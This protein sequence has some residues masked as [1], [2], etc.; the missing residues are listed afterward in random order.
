M[1]QTFLKMQGLGNDFVI[2]DVRKGGAV[3]DIDRIKLVT[4]RRRGIG[5]DQVI[6]ILP[7]R[8][9]K[10]DV[11][12]DMYNPDGSSLQAC[13][14]ATRCVADYLM[15]EK[16]T[17]S[18]V[19][20]TVAGLLH[21]VRGQDGRITIDM[22]IP[23]FEWQQIP[24]AFQCDT[25]HLPIKSSYKKVKDAPVG[26]NIGNPHAV[27]FTDY[28]EE[29]PLAEVGP[30]IENDPFFPE[31][32]NVE[33]AKVLDRTHIRMRVWERGT[34]ETEACGSGACATHIAAVRR[35]YVDR[36]CDVILDGGTLNLY[37]R[38]SDNHIFMTGPVAYVYEGTMLFE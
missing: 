6:H 20:E 13:G 37:W 23:K 16:G 22:G 11:F 14:N 8:S 9:E 24:V 25:L 21:G 4:D 33:F 29:L 30:E 38:E 34:G 7:G 32:V 28:V 3:L 15:R 12:L 18:V 19:I 2:L 1:P 27:F 5:C 31:R 10:A 35:G 17:D 26:V 36:K